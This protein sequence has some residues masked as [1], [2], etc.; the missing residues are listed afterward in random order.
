MSNIRIATI[1]MSAKAAILFC[2]LPFVPAADFG[3]YALATLVFMAAVP[4]VYA[5]ER[6]AA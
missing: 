1:Y 4:A 5:A 2:C 6:G 3:V